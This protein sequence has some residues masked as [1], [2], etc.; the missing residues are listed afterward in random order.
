M[1]S[2]AV[3]ALESVRNYLLELLSFLSISRVDASLMN[4]RALRV[5]FS[6]S[7]ANRRHRLSQAKVRSTT[8]RL[9]RTS[10]PCA[11]SERLTIS[12]ANSAH[13][14]VTGLLL[15]AAALLMIFK[16]TADLREVRP[17]RL[18]PA[19]AVGAGAGFVSGL[20]GVGGGVFVVPVL[21]G[22]GWASARRAAAIAAIHSRKLGRRVAGSSRCRS[23]GRFRRASLFR[24]GNRG[25]GYRRGDWFPVDV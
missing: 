15:L 3:I 14:M 4:A 24:R 20:T 18:G 7:L 12:T 17:I 16:R 11:V 25:R 9:G 1:A 23:E 6:K 5:R 13:F 10:K 22:L 8:Q 2:I 21:V 19:A